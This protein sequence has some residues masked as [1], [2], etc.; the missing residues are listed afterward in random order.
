MAA[1]ATRA[2]MTAGTCDPRPVNGFSTQC[3]GAG[4][5]GA[6]PDTDA[7][8]G[9]NGVTPVSGGC[10]IVRSR[11]VPKFNLAP[12]GLLGLGLF[13]RRIRPPRRKATAVGIAVAVLPAAVRGGPDQKRGRPTG[14]SPAA[15][16]GERRVPSTRA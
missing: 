14:R 13:W 9:S 7:T 3:G 2:P 10:S 12:I 4:D 8:T 15:L 11:N 5:G 16:F 1:P 6:I